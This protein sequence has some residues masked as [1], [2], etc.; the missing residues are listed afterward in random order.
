MAEITDLTPGES[1]T[2][3]L[4][5]L[6]CAPRVAT[7]FYGATRDTTW[8]YH[9]N[10]EEPFVEA[11]TLCLDGSIQF[12]IRGAAVTGAISIDARRFEIY[13]NGEGVELL[14]ERGVD[15]SELRCG[16]ESKADSL[17]QAPS[18]PQS[19]TDGMSCEPIRVLAVSTN[20]ARDRVPDIGGTIRLAINSTN[21]VYRNSAVP[22]TVA[23]LLLVEIVQIDYN[24]AWRITDG[25]FELS[26][27]RQIRDARA[28]TEEEIVVVFT[29][30]PCNQWTYQRGV[31]GVPGTLT[32]DPTRAMAV[33]LADRA[34]QEF[35]ATHEINTLSCDPWVQSFFRLT[36]TDSRGQ[37]SVT[38]HSVMTHEFDDRVC[39]RFNQPSLARHKIDGIVL[40][41]NPTSGKIFFTATAPVSTVV[42]PPTA[43]VF[44]LLGRLVGKF[45]VNPLDEATY[46]VDVS[47]LA[48]GGY[49]RV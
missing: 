16:N 46:S 19:R 36:V 14:L 40:Y 39:P 12:D 10:V 48:P 9:A 24:S 45:P 42:V 25:L 1:F 34:N 4:P 15:S 28:R 26:V 47:N 30:D 7:T 3:T 27:N 23:N 31:L 44:D 21:Q 49:N 20:A 41:P 2:L 38:T 29:D 22:V 11:D 18:R 6:P 33:I 8:A 17:G 32:L 37:T 43:E 5:E 13:H 35:A